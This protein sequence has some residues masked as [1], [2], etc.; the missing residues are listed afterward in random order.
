MDEDDNAF[1]NYLRQFEPRHPGA[2]V[3]AQSEPFLR[4][5]R[6]AAA[7]VLVMFIG[8]SIWTVRRK[9]LPTGGG[10]DATQSNTEARA[11]S[12]LP[13]MPLTKL[14]LEN[15]TGLDAK[16]SEVSRSMLPN[17][18]EAHSTLRVLAKE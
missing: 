12:V 7:A 18:Q 13:L 11:I 9:V 2:L 1:E 14:A 10:A 16:L 3:H 15:P 6:L 4:V 5:R 17:F 8:G